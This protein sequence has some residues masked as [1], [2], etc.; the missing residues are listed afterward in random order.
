[1]ASLL[2][3]IMAVPRMAQA[4]VDPGSGA[5]IWQLAVAG[6]IGSLFYVQRAGR[7][8]R[9][10]LRSGGC[11]EGELVEEPKAQQPPKEETHTAG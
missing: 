4:Y 10:K 8:I 11:T 2:L 5:L 3:M 6:L 7:W 1:M 9:A